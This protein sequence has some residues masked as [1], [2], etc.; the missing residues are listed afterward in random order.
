MTQPHRPG[1]SRWR[2]LAG[3]AATCVVAAAGMTVLDIGP[4]LAVD[5]DLTQY[6]DPFIGTAAS[7]AVNPIAGGAGGNG[8]P[9]ATAPFGRVQWS[10]DT[11]E[12]SGE[13]YRYSDTKINGFSLTH[14]SGAGCPNSQDVP[15]S[16][17]V[18][19]GTTDT[20]IDFSHDDE[21]A[22]PGY[23][24]VELANQV[25]V[26]LT[27]TERTGFGKFTFPS[28]QYANIVVDGS[29]RGSDKRSG[30]VSVDAANK[31][32]SGWVQNG[33]FCNEQNVYKIY[34]SFQYDRPFTVTM[35]PSGD[36]ARRGREQ[37]ER[38][39]GC[40]ADGCDLDHLEVAEP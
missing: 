39:M 19:S 23:Y 9:G 37:G 20:A 8:F 13:S 18:G 34:F 14:L 3:A 1:G 32:V 38:S 27:A 16:A 2:R 35:G 21:E 6:V 10:P 30:S 12:N 7:N 5:E 22:K 17:T 26:E 33:G 36:L 25:Q 15:V 28:T 31:T 29:S 24:R 4:A 40:T 11:K